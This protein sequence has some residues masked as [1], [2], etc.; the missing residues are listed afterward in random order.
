[1]LKKIIILLFMIFF[2]GKPTLAKYEKLAYEFKFKDIDGSELKQITFLGGANWAPFYHPSD[3][4]IIFSSNHQSKR[5]FPFNLYMIDID[6][7]N[8]KQI[9]YDSVFDSFPVF[10]N[11][12][13]KIVFSS[14]RNNGG[15]RN[16]NL[17]IADWL[18]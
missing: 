9:T 1:M 5:G 17:F 13:T 8:L 14:N 11:D 4:K 2:F 7:E 3:K 15:T 10:S 6:G 18:D 16:T 12:G